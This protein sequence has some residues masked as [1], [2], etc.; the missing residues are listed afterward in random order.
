LVVF[1][2][3]ADAF[4][5]ISHNETIIMIMPAICKRP[6][7]SFQKIGPATEGII[8]PYIIQ[9]EVVAIVP[10]RIAVIEIVYRLTTI[11]A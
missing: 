1:R 3:G 6:I 9:M 4:S 8:I 10:T 2:C 5:L 7:G 11:V